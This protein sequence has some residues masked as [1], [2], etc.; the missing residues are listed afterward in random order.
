MQKIAVITGNHKGLGYAI[1]R[2]LAQKGKV[3]FA[4]TLHRQNQLL[5]QPSE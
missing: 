5:K 3:D 1:A 2:Q 4:C